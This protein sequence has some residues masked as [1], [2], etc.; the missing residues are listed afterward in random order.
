M[1]L[2][3]TTIASHALSRLNRLADAID[4]ASNAIRLRPA[5]AHLLHL[6]AQVY[7][8]GPRKLEPAIT[9][10]EAALVR[11]PSSRQV[12]ELLAEC[13]NGDAWL[14]AT[15]LHSHQ[16]MKRALKLSLRAVELVPGQQ[17]SLNT[18]GVL[19]YRAAR[20]ADAVTTLEQ[21]LTAGKGQFDGF[22]LFFL[23]MAHHRLGHQEEAQRCLDRAVTWMSHPV[24]ITADQMKELT[25][26]R[27]EAERVLAGP[28]G[29]M[30]EK[31]FSEA[32]P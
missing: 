25:S 8:R 19:L 2:K 20:Y 24:P 6:R 17:A 26:F 11:S 21:S 22:D 16:D 5:D 12:R 30:P 7:A 29:E 32:K 23:A 15:G 3:P 9:D 31:V 18:R 28:S 4:D 10:L 27:A 14:M 1:T 13:C